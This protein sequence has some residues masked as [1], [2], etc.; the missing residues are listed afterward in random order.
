[1]NKEFHIISTGVSI[2]TNAMHRK[3][4]PEKKII[5][6]DF[7]K[8]CLDD[9]GI[10][11]KLKTMVSE[12]PFKTSAELNTFLRVVAGKDPSKI[13]VYLFG[14]RTHSNE[15]CRRVLESFLKDRGYIIYTPFEVSGY[16]WEAKFYD[17]KFAVDEFKKGIS[18]LL[19]RLITI[20][21]RK[22]DE[23]YEI[24]FNPTGGLKAHVIVSALAGFLVNAN[25]YYMNEEFNKVVFMPP[26]FYLPKGEEINILEKLNQSGQISGKEAEDLYLKKSEEIE[27]LSI[28]GLLELSWDEIQ[29]KVY[30]LRITSKGKVILKKLEKSL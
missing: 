8:S 24:Y 17:D 23:G 26:L 11:A 25:I 16:F 4:I 18:E 10:I 30:R 13:E 14:T 29:Q 22:I 28:Y 5:E 9:Q 19:D 7:W 20:S 1:M 21:R 6:E 15:L 3:I 12:D 2:L 27:R